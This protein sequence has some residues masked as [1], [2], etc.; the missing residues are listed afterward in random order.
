MTARILTLTC[1]ASLLCLG[2]CADAGGDGTSAA[3][4]V[5]QAETA[6]RE[7]KAARVEADRAAEQVDAMAERIALTSTQSLN[8]LREAERALEDAK[9]ALATATAADAKATE[10]LRKIDDAL[11]RIAKLEQGGVV[12]SP[13]GG[14]S[15]DNNAST[16]DRLLLLTA[17]DENLELNRKLL[18]RV[19]QD[20]ERYKA[21]CQSKGLWDKFLK[22]VGNY[23]ATEAE[24]AVG[25]IKRHLEVYFTEFGVDAPDMATL[26][27]D[28]YVTVGSFEG[29]GYDTYTWG[30]AITNGRFVGDIV[31]TSR[32]DQSGAPEVV[33]TYAADGTASIE[34]NGG[35]LN[36]NEL[37]LQEQALEARADMHGADEDDD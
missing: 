7:A 26:E 5:M 17:E 28:G 10:A 29:E 2:A 1:A 15:S 13:T 33:I 30:G 20:Y 11:A 35:N 8:A 37:W 31:G 25:S 19:L 22:K 12:A 21:L 18:R 34:H 14:L 16:T 9:V 6:E 32:I 3:A 23:R 27:A 4:L 24:T 36:Q